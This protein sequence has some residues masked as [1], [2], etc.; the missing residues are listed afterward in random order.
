[1]RARRLPASFA[2]F[3]CAIAAAPAA[4][5]QERSR[6]AD[7]PREPALAAIAADRILADLFYVASDDM[8]GR[9][10]PSVGERLTA[11]F[12]VNRLQRLRW[13]PGNGSSWLQTY[14]LEQRTADE[15]GCAARV[16]ADEQSVDLKLADDYSFPPLQIRSHELE[17]GVVSMGRGPVAAVDDRTAAALKDRWAWFPD[18]GSDLDRLDASLRNAGAVGVLTT[19]DVVNTG[20]DPQARVVFKL[21][22]DMTRRGVVSMPSPSPVLPRVYLPKKTNDKLRA[23][24]GAVEPEV[25][26]VMPFTFAETRRASHADTIQAENVVGLWPGS[27]PELGRQV[28]LVSA[29]YDTLGTTKSSRVYAGADDNGSGTVALL[30]LADALVAQ[31]PL[32]CSVMLVWTS[33]EEKGLWGSQ[34]FVD[35]PPLP[36]GS[37]AVANINLDMVGREAAPKLSVTPFAKTHPAWS[38]L[39]RLAAEAAREE[40]FSELGSADDYFHRS[41]NFN[42][43]RLGI[44]VVSL[45]DGMQVD[46]HQPTDTPD[47]IDGDKI[48]R[49]TRM[50]L[51][52]LVRLEGDPVGRVK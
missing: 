24:A 38:G 15:K 42:F 25:G 20:G 8:G 35:A 52:M 1:M 22:A 26:D 46:Y 14:P 23:M 33:G 3:A 30:A 50:V 45:F 18:K 31:G 13:Q 29:H 36:A 41:D 7:A 16:R 49:V 48:A 2:F 27:D 39:A 11:R 47:K 32:R 37:R 6:P 9:A 51:R 34:A 4:R 17:G 12:L 5:A 40:G 44:P 10:T 21:Y 28:V 43:A 19:I